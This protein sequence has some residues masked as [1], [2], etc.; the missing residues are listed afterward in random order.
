MHNVMITPTP[1]PSSFSPS[2]SSRHQIT[3]ASFNGPRRNG[4][5]LPP[6]VHGSMRGRQGESLRAVGRETLSLASKRPASPLSEAH[7]G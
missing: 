1:R 5:M 3:R 2:S 6:N 7:D 4:A